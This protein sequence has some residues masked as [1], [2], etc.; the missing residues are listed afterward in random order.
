M[1]TPNVDPKKVN[2]QPCLIVGLV[3]HLQGGD[4][5]GL[6][7]PRF[8]CN[9]ESLTFSASVDFVDSGNACFPCRERP[10]LRRSRWNIKLTA[11]G[12]LLASYTTRSSLTITV[13]LL[14]SLIAGNRSYLPAGVVIPPLTAALWVTRL[15]FQL[16]VVC[17][18]V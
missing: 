9:P 16:G 8:H 6:N 17:S 2:E 1:I 10:S 3:K 14:S 7:G 12:C 18:L 4:P 13:K 5:E 11:N 15:Q